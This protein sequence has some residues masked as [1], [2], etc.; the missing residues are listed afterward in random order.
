MS[1]ARQLL[2]AW[3]EPGQGFCEQGI[4]SGLVDGFR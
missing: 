4:V 2:S 3:H 1:R